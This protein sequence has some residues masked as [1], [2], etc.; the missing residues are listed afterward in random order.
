MRHVLVDDYFG[1]NLDEV[2]AVV[3]RDL[4][5]LKRQVKGVLR[6]RT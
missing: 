3:E 4:P 1:I 6:E 2:W 5:G